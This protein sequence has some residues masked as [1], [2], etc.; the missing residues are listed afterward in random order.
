MDISGG[1]IAGH[2]AKAAADGTVII[3]G[4]NGSY[5]NMVTVDHGGGITTTYAHGSAVK[6]SAG[7]SVKKGDTLLVIGTT[8]AS[9]GPHLHFEVR[10]NGTPVNPMGYLR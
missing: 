1:G 9:T 3:A 5:G 8:G 7:Q 10:E 6:V 4:W 2:P